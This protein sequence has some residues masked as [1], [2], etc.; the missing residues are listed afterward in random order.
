MRNPLAESI[1]FT[2]VDSRYITVA[3]IRHLSAWTVVLIAVV[4]MAVLSDSLKIPDL[5][6]R[7]A[8]GYVLVTAALDVFIARRRAK[9][10]GYAEL[11][12]EL[13]VVH[14]IMFRRLEVVPYGRMQQVNLG[15]GPLMSLFDLASVELVTASAT[16]DATIPGVK[17]SEAD[18]LRAKLTALGEAKLEGL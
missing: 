5:V 1:E 17:K 4:V 15:T 9:V 2:P 8:L 10:V 18:R 16:T 14:G 6:W 13:V 12:N 3:T 7:I 11:E